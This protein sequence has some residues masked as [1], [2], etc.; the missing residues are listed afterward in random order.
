MKLLDIFKYSGNAIK[1]QKMRTFLTTLG[2]IIGIAAI[3][4]LTSL[5]EGLSASISA[6]F[7]EGFST[8][9]LTVSKAGGGFGG[10][11]ADA[12]F[13]MLLEDVAIFD[14]IEHIELAMAV[15]QKT[16]TLEIG[17]TDTTVVVYGVDLK[18]YTQIYRTFEA[19]K[20][21]IPTDS[22][23]TTIVIGHSIYLPWNNNTVAYDVSDD[24]TIT[25]LEKVGMVYED[26]TYDSTVGAV[27]A[28]I[29]GMGFGPSDRGLYMQI[30]KASEIFDT[31]VVSQFIVLLDD[32]SDAVI[33][34]VSA[35][36][37]EAFG[38]QVSVTSATAILDT[39]SSV[40][41]TMQIFLIAISGIS[42]VVAGIGIMNIMIV[43]VMERT[44]EIGIIK[45]LGLKNRSILLVFL[46]ESLLI[47]LIGS[48]LGILAG[49]FGGSFLMT[50][51][52][53][54][55]GGGGLPGGGE[56]GGMS[57]MGFGTI[58]PVISWTLIGTALLFGVA[59]AVIFGLYPAWRA[60]KMEP[61][62]AL[63]YE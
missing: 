58:T 60:S 7:E 34:A 37:E 16:C 38:D 56:G 29:G 31:E 36:I 10:G 15:I 41:G 30:D 21:V 52:S 49:W 57:T 4:A 46:F 55:M 3:V 33:E 44:R 51:I 32:D 24:I 50:M 12:D 5:T 11:E 63:R 1:T 19:E 40:F 45:A 25:W 42:L 39:I 54:M 23:N 26:K 48:V 9:A 61:V 18:K 53:A 59:V 22:G 13:D 17:G 62:E 14:S 28:E 43:S 27:I 2:V 20:G 8:K 35:E 47:G 6:Q